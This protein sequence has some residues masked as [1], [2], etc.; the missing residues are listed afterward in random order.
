MRVIYLICILFFLSQNIL[1]SKT[2][3]AYPLF[4]IMYDE[5]IEYNA[6]EKYTFYGRVCEK[7]INK[8]ALGEIKEIN[9]FACDTDFPEVKLDIFNFTSNNTTLD[10]NQI[11]CFKIISTHFIG[12]GITMSANIVKLVQNCNLIDERKRSKL[13]TTNFTKHNLSRVNISLEGEKISFSGKM[14]IINF[15]GDPI[16]IG[17]IDRSGLG[18]INCNI[19]FEKNSFF[20]VPGMTESEKKEMIKKI[21]KIRN[22]KNPKLTCTGDVVYHLYGAEHGFT[23]LLMRA[24]D[25]KIIKE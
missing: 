25:L 10:L 23:T 6:L 18:G 4:S 3:D 16:Q 8:N 12:S 15:D 20:G 11:I 19:H 17:F 24:N 9:Y 21:K 7:K 5:K 1:L 13:K 2:V 22:L 14:K